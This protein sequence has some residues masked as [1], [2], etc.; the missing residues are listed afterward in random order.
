MKGPLYHVPSVT[1]R[2]EMAVQQVLDEHSLQA[3]VRRS[4]TPPYEAIVDLID[5][6]VFRTEETGSWT[7]LSRAW[8][9]LTRFAVAASIGRRLA[10]V[11][12]SSDAQLFADTIT[13]LLRGNT[14]E[15]ARTYPRCHRARRRPL[16]RA[17]RPG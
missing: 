10:D 9:T 2:A 4:H 17:P 1:L 5:E 3:P 12:H 11:V 6:V 7:F 15:R 16:D 13:P 14:A 8:T